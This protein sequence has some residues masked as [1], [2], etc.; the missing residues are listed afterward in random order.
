[1][2]AETLRSR[3]LYP[4]LMSSR[5]SGRFGA[6]QGIAT[7]GAVLSPAPRQEQQ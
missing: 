1:M 4:K 5:G 6:A 3:I 2:A 7:W